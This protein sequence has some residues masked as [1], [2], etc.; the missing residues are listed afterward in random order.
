[1]ERRGRT[2]ACAREVVAFELRAGRGK[3]QWAS[4]RRRQKRKGN[5]EGKATEMKRNEAVGSFTR[6]ESGERP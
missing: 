2:E 1:L 3:E 4:G 5:G 6:K